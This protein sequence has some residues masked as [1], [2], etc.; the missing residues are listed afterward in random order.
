M[1]YPSR[2]CLLARRRLCVVG[3]CGL[4]SC[5]C[6]PASRAV[7]RFASRPCLLD[8]CRRMPR[9]FAPSSHHLVLD[10]VPLLRRASARASS[11]LASPRHLVARAVPLLLASPP[12]LID[13]TG[14][15][16]R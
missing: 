1:L 14:G 13:T 7:G 5:G 11:R 16:I 3:R 9:R 8:V 4:V 15:E 6:R 12:R 10:C 2:L